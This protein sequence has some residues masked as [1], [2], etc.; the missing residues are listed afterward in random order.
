MRANGKCQRG[1]NGRFINLT[2]NPS[3]HSPEH[4]AAKPV[5]KRSKNERVLTE[6]KT[7][8]HICIRLSARRLQSFLHLP[9]KH[10]QYLSRQARLDT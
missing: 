2:G 7:S 10:V 6:V 3:I 8:A 4:A 1:R 9:T 5:I